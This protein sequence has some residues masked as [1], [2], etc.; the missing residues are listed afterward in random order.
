MAIR[1]RN[2]SQGYMSPTGFHPIRS[3]A[4]YDPSRAGEVKKKA[5]KAT[6][7]RK[8]VKKATKKAKKATKKTAKKKNPITTQWKTAKVR[9]TKS[10][11]IQL[12]L[13]GRAK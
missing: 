13:P 2:I 9:R 12:L 6:R 3:A 11:L 4:D 8:A 1:V 5:K 7:K 10:G